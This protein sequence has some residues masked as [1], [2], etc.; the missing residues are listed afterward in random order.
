MKRAAKGLEQDFFTGG[1]EFVIPQNGRIF[2]HCYLDPQNPPK[3]I[4][5][6]FHTTGWLHRAVWGAEDLIP[7]ASRSPR[8]RFP[9]VRCLRLENG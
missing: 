2:V 7:L 6:Q 9:W 1:A 4:M 5:M 8:R 3:T